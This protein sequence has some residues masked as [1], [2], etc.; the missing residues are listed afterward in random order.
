MY[1]T[2]SEPKTRN[3]NG[4]IGVDFNKGFIAVSEI[5]ETGKL[6]NLDRFNYIHKGKSGVTKNSMY[7]LVKDL[8]NLAI[9]SGKDIVIED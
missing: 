8:V 3:S 5:D 6:L 2:E 7:H 1:R 9:K 4:V